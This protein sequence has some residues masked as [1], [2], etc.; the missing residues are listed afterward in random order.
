MINAIGDRLNVPIDRRPDCL[1]ELE[2]ALALHELAFGQDAVNV[3]I[4][5]MHWTD[6]GR[7]ATELI[8]AS[9]ELVLTLE[10]TETNAVDDEGDGK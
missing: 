8:D 5:P 10:V 7:T 1:R 4:G 2:Y 9:G 6:D 3:P